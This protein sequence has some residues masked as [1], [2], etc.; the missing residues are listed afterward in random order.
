MICHCHRHAFSCSVK[1][2][3]F[4]TSTELCSAALWLEGEVA[5]DAVHAGQRHSELL[6][7][8]IDALLRC[9]GIGVRELDAIAYGEGPGSFTGLRIACGV[10]QGLAFG[11]NL[12]VVGIGTLLALA[13]ASGETEAVCCL[14]ARMR[15]VYFAA[16]RRN[17]DGWETVR[18]PQVHAPQ[19]VPEL[20]SGAWTGC[21]NGFVVYAD[22][23]RARL[24][25][26]LAAVAPIELPHA[27]EIAIL[28][29]AEVARGGGK[30]AAEAVPVYVRDKVALTIEEQP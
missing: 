21:G 14:D 8:M 29:A 1:L 3:A 11:A 7:P 13:Q 23:L 10:A 26:A 17:A 5:A 24:G 4:D 9:A 16:Y 2:L 12:P 25:A 30:P 19:A 18:S 20:P 22:A 15:Q 6:L 28:A 27:R